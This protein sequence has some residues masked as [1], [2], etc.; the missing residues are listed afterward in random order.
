MAA[1]SFDATSID[2][3]SHD[4]VPAGT[5][6]AV[7][8][9]SE[10]KATK[11]GTGKGLNLTLEILSDGAAKGRKVWDWINFVHSNPEA[12]RIG[13]ETLAKLCKA[14]N[15]SQLT[16][17]VQLHGLPVMITVAV[18]RNDPTRNVI[19][20]YA[21]KTGS[22]SASVAQAATTTAAATGAAPWAR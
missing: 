14:V 19:K 17:T 2:T 6:E 7:V 18:D 10:V 9:A 11:S 20:G 8:T 15:V 5:Y 16:D 12:E 13:K 21:A 22:A 4:L 3:T 1:I